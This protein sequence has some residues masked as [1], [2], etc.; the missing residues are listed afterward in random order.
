MEQQKQEFMLDFHVNCHLYGLREGCN[1]SSVQHCDSVSGRNLF[2]AQAGI[3]KL[4]GETGFLY[5]Y[6]LH[7]VRNYHHLEAVPVIY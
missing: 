5:S 1:V 2:P 3:N 6:D 4:H 7:F